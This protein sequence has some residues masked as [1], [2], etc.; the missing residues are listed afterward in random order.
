MIDDESDNDGSDSGSA[1]TCDFNF[2]FEYSIGHEDASVVPV[3]GVDSSV[4]VTIGIESSFYVV[5]LI[6]LVPIEV[7]Y[8]VGRLIE[9]FWRPKS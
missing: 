7:K 9:I 2:R 8:K 3:R 5:P 4:F 1:G 6:V